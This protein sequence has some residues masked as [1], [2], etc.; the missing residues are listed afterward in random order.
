MEA[1]AEGLKS[2]SRDNQPAAVKGPQIGTPSPGEI[3]VRQS[4][5]SR[6]EVLYKRRHGLGGLVV[7]DSPLLRDYST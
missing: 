7:S 6:S 5:S 1:S 2:P 4:E 3:D